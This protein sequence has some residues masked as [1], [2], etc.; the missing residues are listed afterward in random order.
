MSSLDIAAFSGSGA[1]VFEGLHEE[2]K[3]RKH[4]SGVYR[5]R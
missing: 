3:I 2:E 5:M 4:S 1:E